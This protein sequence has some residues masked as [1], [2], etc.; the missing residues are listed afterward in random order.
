VLWGRS[1]A[2]A[3]YAYSVVLDKVLVVLSKFFGLQFVN[4][5]PALVLRKA[6]V[7]KN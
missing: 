3:D 4:C 1:T 6:S 2:T 5:V 7:R